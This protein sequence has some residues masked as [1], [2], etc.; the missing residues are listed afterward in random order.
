MKIIAI[1]LPVCA[2]QITGLLLAAAQGDLHESGQV[3]SAARDRLEEFLQR[4]PVGDEPRFG[5]RHRNEFLEATAGEPY[6]MFTVDSRDLAS[7][8][9]PVVRPLNSWRVPVCVRDTCRAFLTVEKS[10][11]QWRAVDFGAAQLAR[12]IAAWQEQHQ[13]PAS[14]SSC[15]IVRL[16]DSSCDLLILYDPARPIVDA[17]VSPL[18]S[19]RGALSRQNLPTPDLESVREYLPVLVRLSPSPTTQR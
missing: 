10:G 13:I 4:I 16:F 18:A 8:R 5:F 2:L 3:R 14:T 9:E 1:V 11:G 19:A 12:E 6:R 17:S 15:G 7:G